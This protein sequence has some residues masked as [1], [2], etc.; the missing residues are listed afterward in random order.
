M[1]SL[2]FRKWSPSGLLNASDAT[3]QLQSAHGSNKLLIE[4]SLGRERMGLL[5][6]AGIV[7]EGFHRD[8]LPCLMGEQGGGPVGG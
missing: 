2:R 7:I 5:S 8:F 4:S 1:F 6:N 3:V